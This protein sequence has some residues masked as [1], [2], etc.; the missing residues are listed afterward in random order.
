MAWPHCNMLDDGAQVNEPFSFVVRADDVGLPAAL[1]RF[2][3]SPAATYAGVPASD[4]AC[5]FP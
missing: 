3:A 5:P 1:D 4:P 2:I